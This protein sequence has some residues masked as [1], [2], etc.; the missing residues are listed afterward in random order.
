MKMF[1]KAFSIILCAVMIFVVA[2]PAF[3]QSENVICPTI[4][5]PGI[6]SSYIYKDVSN[7]VEGIN[8]IDKDAVTAMLKEE[9]VPALIV[10]AADGDADN[11]AHKISNVVNTIFADYFNDPDG[12]AAG[13]SGVINSYPS[14]IRKNANLYFSYDWRGD[15]IVIASELDAY[16]DYVIEKSGVDKVALTSHSM[17]S[18][19]ILSYLSLYGDDKVAGIVLDSPVIEGVTYVGELLCGEAEFTSEGFEMFFKSVMGET[20]Y[21]ELAASSMDILEMAGVSGLATDFLG[22]TMK[23]IGPVFFR[24]SL[25]PLFGR[26]LT[27]WA[28]CPEGKMEQAIDF[29]FSNMPENEDANALRAKIEDYNARVR[30]NRMDT[31]LDF[32]EKGR[33]AV[34]SRYGYSSLPVTASWDLLGDAVV[35]TESSSF[36]ATTAVFGDYFDDAYLEGKDMKYISPDKTVD[37]STCLFPEKTWFI[38]NLIHTQAGETKDIK[39]QLLFGEKEAVCDDFSMG[40]FIIYDVE[41]QTFS[42]DNSVPV[43]VEKPT[44]LQRLFNFLKAFFEK[45]IDFFTRKKD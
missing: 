43:K 5:L 24:E 45:I 7:P 9:I 29:V 21:Q 36:G 12:T 35:E 3:A 34:I 11:L 42:I 38:K 20:E 44:P 19:I 13:N 39:A 27:I 17:G 6:D 14:V 33:L 4:Y 41:T 1:K 8:E 26:W 2:V 15:P 28:M 23:K 31:L 37:A 10:Y 32:D 22:D 25:V 16:I 40:R 30:E 18:L